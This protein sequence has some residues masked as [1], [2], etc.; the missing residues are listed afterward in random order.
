[1]I[2][3]KKSSDLNTPRTHP[4]GYVRLSLYP[5]NRAGALTAALR[6]PRITGIGERFLKKLAG[7]LELTGQLPG[8]TL[9]IV[10]PRAG[11]ARVS[12]V[13]EM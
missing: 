8:R 4:L 2:K 3:S 9:Q 6:D 10:P 11:G 5:A 1:M 13:S 12:R 7:L